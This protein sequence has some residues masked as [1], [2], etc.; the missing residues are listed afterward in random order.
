[1]PLVK[2]FGRITGKL[3]D[4]PATLDCGAIIDGTRP[5]HQMLIFVHC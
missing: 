1:M 5:A 2:L 4:N 3:V